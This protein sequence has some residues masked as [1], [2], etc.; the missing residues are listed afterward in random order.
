MRIAQAELNEFSFV[1]RIT[2]E[3]IFCI[4]TVTII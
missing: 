4:T 3:T 2:Q 1:K